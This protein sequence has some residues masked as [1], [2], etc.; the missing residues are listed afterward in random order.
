MQEDNDS[1]AAQEEYN[2]AT[3][4]IPFFARYWINKFRRRNGLAT[5]ISV[6]L[7]EKMAAVHKDGLEY[8]AH[9]ALYE[10]T[11][12][13]RKFPWGT[14]VHVHKVGVHRVLEFVENEKTWFVAQQD[15]RRW[16]GRWDSFDAALIDAIASHYEGWQSGAGYYA[17]KV[18]GLEGRN[19]G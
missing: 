14:F 9:D 13:S 4:E 16:G 18:A 3:K 8:G 7:A 6:E 17:A 5:D 1:V 2:E 11:S 19:D 15:E 10:D 12:E